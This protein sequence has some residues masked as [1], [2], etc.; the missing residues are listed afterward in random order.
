MSSDKLNKP[1]PFYFSTRDLLLTAVLAAL[2][3][4]SSTYIN[5][6]GDAVHAA[7]GLPGATQ[8]AAGLHVIWLVLAAGLLRKPGSGTVTGIFKGAIELLSGNTHGVIILLVDLV[9]GLLVDFGFL[10]SRKN[11]TLFPYLLGGGLATGSNVFV[12]QLFATIPLNMLGL[13]AILL[14]FLIAFVSGLI[15]S[16]II[17]Y[18]LV[19]SLVKA[20]VVRIPEQPQQKK[21]VGWWILLGVFI[22]AILLG[23]FLKINFR[24]S[25]TISISGAVNNQYDFP[26]RDPQPDQVT[27]KMDYR[28][29]MTEYMGYPLEEII[30]D[31]DPDA[32][33]DTILIEASDGYAFLIS[34]E[35]LSSNKNIL[36]VKSGQGE[37]ASFDIVGPESSKAWVR[38]VTQIIVISAEGLQI[39]DSDRNT[40]LFD[41]GEWLLEMDSTQISLPQGTQ[42]LQGVSVW[43]IIDEYITGNQPSEVRF[44][45]TEDSITISWAEIEN[46][47]NM[48]VF[49]VIAQDGIDFA[50]AEMSGELILY[51]LTMIEVQ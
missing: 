18:L 45:A 40:Y 10:V 19:N 31:A 47:D 33:A 23:I 20:G 26:E 8:W 34:F 44:S 38:N 48:R 16:G 17:P 11:R 27:R 24:G 35:E 12:F 42:K 51:P 49:T 6:L 25:Q 36:L 7:L 43:K 15:F 32:N 21:K 30:M 9:A 39:L 2:G 37:N 5:T 29:V 13:S 46:N 3:G 22:L 50:L 4:V 1:S 28:G 14:L 41:P